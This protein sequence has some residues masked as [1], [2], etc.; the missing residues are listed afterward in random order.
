M[1]DLI[2]GAL[3]CVRKLQTW[4]ERDL[5]AWK[6]F[7]LHLKDNQALFAV[8]ERYGRHKYLFTKLLVTIKFTL[9]QILDSFYFF[10]LCVCFV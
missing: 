8:I 5:S 7:M 6:P 9:I 3:Q 1:C 4:I 2:A 10:V